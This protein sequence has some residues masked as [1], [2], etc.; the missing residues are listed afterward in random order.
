MSDER[1]MVMSQVFLVIRW[2]KK[3]TKALERRDKKRREGKR[4]R[5]K[6]EREKINKRGEYRTERD[7]EN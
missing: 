5:K 6:G 4:W 1:L 3:R 2:R 7:R